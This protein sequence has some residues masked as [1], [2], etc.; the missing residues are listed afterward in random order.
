L[1]LQRKKVMSIT[2]SNFEKEKGK[3]RARL[4]CH[5][6]ENELVDLDMRVGIG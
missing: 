3:R 1:E 2:D 4:V 5:L 6:S